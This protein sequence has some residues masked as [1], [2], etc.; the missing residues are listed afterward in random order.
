MRFIVRMGLCVTLAVGAC[1][2]DPVVL[3]GRLPTKVPDASIAGHPATSPENQ[4]CFEVDPVC[5]TDGVTYM[6]FCK[7]A[8]AGASIAKRGPC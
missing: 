1:T 4:E 8:L 6:N 5:G 3:L 2:S 7:A